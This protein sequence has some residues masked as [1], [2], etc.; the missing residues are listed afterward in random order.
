[1]RVFAR[2]RR[3]D[4]PRL[5]VAL[6]LDDV[7]FAMQPLQSAANRCPA[8]AQPLGDLRLDNPRTGRQVAAYDELPQFLEG[9]RDAAG[10]LDLRGFFLLGRRQTARMLSQIAAERDRRAR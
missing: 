1:T 9:F 3:H 2:Q 10:V 7:P 5:A 8:E 4:N 6:V